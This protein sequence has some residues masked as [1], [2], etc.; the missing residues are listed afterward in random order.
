MNDTKSSGWKTLR[1][2]TLQPHH[3]PT[4]NTKHLLGSP[5]GLQKDFP[6]FVWLEIAQFDDDPGFYL[7]YHSESGMDADTWHLSL[8]D[9]MHQA[10]FEFNVKPDEWLPDSASSL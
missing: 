5:D 1:Q 6:P 10:E 7:L 3:M 2:I 8:E 9:A 4:G